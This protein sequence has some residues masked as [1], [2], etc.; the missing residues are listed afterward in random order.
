[1]VSRLT[2][3]AMSSK[4]E[5]KK[6]NIRRVKKYR[7]RRNYLPYIVLVIIALSGWGIGLLVMRSH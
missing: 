2:L 1:M 6:T 7:H 3:I 5:V 4:F